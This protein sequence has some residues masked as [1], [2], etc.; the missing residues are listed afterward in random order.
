MRSTVG[1]SV[2]IIS[3]TIHANQQIDDFDP[4][5][6][7]VVMD[8]WLGMKRSRRRVG[9]TNLKKD[10]EGKGREF[11]D[12]QKLKRGKSGKGR[13]IKQKDGEGQKGWAKGKKSEGKKRGKKGKKREERGAQERVLKRVVVECQFDM[14]KR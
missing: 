13:G 14:S 10:T 8:W 2:D 11:R 12:E 5:D 3:V 4:N 7:V 9:K 1:G 6:D